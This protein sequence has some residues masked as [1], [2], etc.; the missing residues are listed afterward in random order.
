MR[1]EAIPVSAFAVPETP[2]TPELPKKPE[3]LFAAH[4]ELVR[5]TDEIA[6]ADVLD[7]RRKLWVVPTLARVVLPSAVVF[8]MTVSDNSPTGYI[9]PAVTSALLALGTTIHADSRD[10]AQLK[11]AYASY[12]QESIAA[13]DM[14]YELFRTRDKSGRQQ[15]AMRWYGPAN[16]DQGTEGAARLREAAR[17]AEAN[18]VDKLLLGDALAS[19]FILSALPGNEMSMAAWLRK[20]K[21]LYTNGDTDNDRIHEASP[22]DWLDTLKTGRLRTSAASILVHPASTFSGEHAAVKDDTIFPFATAPKGDV[23]AKFSTT[24]ERDDVPPAIL[25]VAKNEH[26]VISQAHGV[27]KELALSQGP[28]SREH[29]RTRGQSLRRFV[30]GMAV[31]ATGLILAAGTAHYDKEYEEVRRQAAVDIAREQGAN[32]NKVTVDERAVDDRITRYDQGGLANN[33][34][35]KWR[36]IRNVVTDGLEKLKHRNDS[37]G[38]GGHNSAEASINGGVGNVEG[39]DEVIPVWHLTPNN[40]S[41]EGS[42]PAAVSANLVID[43]PSSGTPGMKWDIAE[44]YGHSA[45]ID[46]PPIEL[47]DTGANAHWIKVERTIGDRDS[48]DIGSDN[49]V[50]LPVLSGTEVAAA[51]F[52]G[53]PV[54]LW[55][56]ANGTYSLF[57][58][59]AEKV[60]PPPHGKVTYW[61]RPT[62]AA[63]VVKAS[64]PAIV[65]EV[66]DSNNTRGL[67]A[68]DTQQIL[69]RRIPGYQNATTDKERS[70][71]VSDYFHSEFGYDFMPL[72]EDFF[73]DYHGAEDFT[74]KVLDVE[75]ANCNVAGS[76]V[77]LQDHEWNGVLSFNHKNPKDPN[78]LT[79]DQRHFTLVNMEGDQMD[80]TPPGQTPLTAVASQRGAHKR[81]GPERPGDVSLTLLGVAALA[82]LVERKREALKAIGN[83]ANDRVV[84][85]RADRAD[86]QLRSVHGYTLKAAVEV[87]DRIAWRQNGPGDI[88]GILDSVAKDGKPAELAYRTLLQ[89]PYHDTEMVQ[90]VQSSG[91]AT[92][93]M[94]RAY[95]LASRAVNRPAPRKTT[96]RRGH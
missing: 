73:R 23:Y 39:G 64:Y 6:G 50:P 78:N 79:T 91:A 19:R 83:R 90:A 11:R 58:D 12:G 18:D 32:P 68:Y 80:P 47:A 53:K 44:Q 34:W 88:Q 85:F 54:A 94:M 89:R 51:N 95:E 9:L 92:P 13:N 45:R 29:I 71:L 22:R 10:N 17:L 31:M 66:T 24:I 93:D 25:H 77:V 52:D 67:A 4:V 26:L 59:G 43:L 1:A 87:V 41:T 82:T 27:Q 46:H 84:T 16:G 76:F 57:F 56:G 21:H 30:G 70:Q 96:P 36:G 72:P 14:S 33:V 62:S 2:P 15:V 7:I 81:R 65:T 8:G 86:K 60:S 48:F 3:E 75:K 42:W 61:V 5:G 20:N 69:N 28:G 40:M 55:A 63:H 74:K 49:Y 37:K 35:G 38:E